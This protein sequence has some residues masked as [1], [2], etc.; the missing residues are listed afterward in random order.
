MQPIRMLSSSLSSQIS[1]GEVIE[2]PS[3]VIK[4]LLENSI[5][6][7]AKNIDISV[8]RSGL[9]S[10]T[11]KDDGF[12]IEKD[13]LLLAISRHATSKI[14]RLSDLDNINTFGF[15]GEALASIR[16]VSR[17]KLI[18]C[19]QN[20]N[21][22]WSIYSEGFSNHTLL[23][24]IAHPIGTSIIVDNLFYNIPVRLKFIKNERSEFLK[25]DETIKK[26]AL[27]NFG[28]N[29]FFKKDKKL[30]VSYKAITKNNN[31]IHR[32]KTVFNQIDLNYVLEIKEKMHN[33]TL[34]GW[35]IFPS[36]LSS[37]FKKIQYC[38]V[39]NR[40]VYNNLIKSAV[41]NSFYEIIGNKRSTSF[42]LYLTLPSNEIDINIHPTK[43]E[44]KFHKSNII[45][46]F[47]YQSILSSLK[48]CKIKYISNNF[49]LKTHSNKCKNN[50][51]DSLNTK[52]VSQ[53]HSKYEKKDL[54]KD[55]ISTDLFKINS[56]R[57][58]KEYF[59][60]FG[61]LL[62]VFQKYYGLMY[63]SNTFS[64]IS[65]P[66]AKKIVEQYKLRSA[67]KN[68][69]I[70]EI[71]SYNFLY[72]ITFKQNK[73][74][75]NNLKLLLKFGF[76]LILKEKY[77]F[78]KTIPIFLKNQNLDVLLS[79]FFS[80]IFFKKK[81]YIKDIIKWFD[82]TILIEKNSWNYED[83]ISILLE[84]EYFCPSIF[85]KPPLKLLQKINVDEVLCILKV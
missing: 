66:L 78:L 40:F 64:L 22:A 46:F 60:S 3:S 79:S 37:T 2:R 44:I 42:I 71:F 24:P 59:F 72:F 17:M 4:E 70:P 30:F 84:I 8:E 82:T 25:I 48:K 15:R 5:D 32:L 83:G 10:I 47:V 6:A 50:N 34:F 57:F 38:Y 19:S 77:F 52:L 31:K 67:I 74:L 45:Y 49:F 76:N 7:Q 73:I 12:G 1:A 28:I 23:Q 39:N 41:F 26:I 43:N 69:M 54:Y 68:N 53:I 36:S 63:Y 14:N 56:Q 55:V 58:L 80:F 81:I 13:Q 65:F 62:I 61:K 33:I 75:S 35:L 27:S 29:I 51:S 9:N 11:V 18:S 85:K 21:I 20:S 16:A